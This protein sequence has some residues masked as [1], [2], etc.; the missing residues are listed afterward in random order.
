M[1]ELKPLTSAD[2]SFLALCRSSRSKDYTDQVSAGFAL[3]SVGVTHTD[4][5][6]LNMNSSSSSS[7]DCTCGSLCVFLATSS[8][9]SFGF[10]TE[11]RKRTSA[12]N[13]LPPQSTWDAE[14]SNLESYRMWCCDCA[15]VL[16]VLEPLF[17]SSIDNR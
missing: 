12:V 6:A 9:W 15:Y 13:H 4:T 2:K 14:I 10:K 17:I 7:S 5:L 1:T 3:K 8:C 16:K 11:I